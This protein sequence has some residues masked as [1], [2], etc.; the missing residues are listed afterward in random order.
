MSQVE[1]RAQART[2]RRNILAILLV[3]VL[4]F[5]SLIGSYEFALNRQNAP[6]LSTAAGSPPPN[7]RLTAQLSVKVYHKGALRASVTENNDLVMN[8]FMNFLPSWMTYLS[9]SGPASTFTMTDT[10]G[11]PLTLV[12]R[13]SSNTFAGCTWTCESTVAPFAGGYIAIGTGT[14]APART[15][16]KLT[17][18][19]QTP[20]TVNPPTYDPTTGDI[21]FGTGIVAG[22]A[23]SIG[24]AGFLENWYIGG[25]VWVNF[26]MFHDTFPTIAVSPGNTISVQYTVQLGSTAYNN[27]LGVLLATIFANPL[28]SASS[29]KLTPTSGPAQTISVYTIGI[30]DGSYYEDLNPAPRADLSSGTTGEDSA[31][32]VGTGSASACPDDN[33]AFAQSRSATNLCQPVLTP[34]PVN[35]FVFSPYVAVTAVI[36]TATAQTFTEAGYFQSFGSPTY[37]FRLI[38]NTFSGLPVPA[39]SSATVTYEMSMG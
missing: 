14:N 12:G 17:A 22:T 8:N 21:V 1:Y 3:V 26:L 25:T 24:E 28:G 7:F 39:D 27:N 5:S 36:P 38:R 11:T 13:D 29:V 9:L 35:S 20:V 4:G 16:Y 33:G 34:S 10:A 32:I 23:A 2:N 15:D 19:Y 30:L 18:P 31:V 6:A 37:S